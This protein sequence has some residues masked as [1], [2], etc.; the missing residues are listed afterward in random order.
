MPAVASQSLIEITGTF[1]AELIRFDDYAVVAALTDGTRLKGRA[2]RGDL[3]PGIPYKFVGSWG[4]YRG[5]RQFLFKQYIKAEPHTKHGVVRYL[6]VTAPHIGPVLA[7][8]LWDEFRQ[9]AV[10]VLRTEPE[11]ASAAI[12]GLPLDRAMEAAAALSAHESLEETRIDLMDLFAGR[13][14]P[15]TLVNAV[16]KRWGIHAPVVIRRDPFSLLVEDFHGCGFARCDRLYCDLGLPLDA[17]KRQMICLWNAM[18]EQ[19]N[20]H[21]WHLLEAIEKK[22]RRLVSGKVRPK[23]AI[24][25]GV[26]SG[27]LRTR[28]DERGIEWI[29]VAEN[30]EHEAELAEK[31][32]GLQ[33]WVTA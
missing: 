27:W 13:G 2:E 8:R 29:A 15:G 31:V 5:Q 7:G 3:I 9:D 4:E 32:K 25:L 30:A 14:F 1:Q 11:R 24:E 6:E 17:L 21:T 18:Q 16:L 23:R 28:E 10:K 12:N 26:R 33:K 20:G 19:N 22:M